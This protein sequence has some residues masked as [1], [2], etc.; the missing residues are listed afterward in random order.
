MQKPHIPKP[1]HEDWDAMT[2]QSGG[3]HC[4]KCDKV[5]I[6][7]TQNSDL[8]IVQYVSQFSKGSICG[9]ISANRQVTH[10]VFHQWIFTLQ[11]KATNI[12]QYF[13][14]S[15]L[16]YLIGLIMFVMGCEKADDKEKISIGSVR[17]DKKYFDSLNTDTSTPMNGRL[18]LD[19][20]PTNKEKNYLETR[21]IRRKHNP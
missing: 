8:E 19:I 17:F 3:R 15:I 7:F 13:T 12:N 20:I 9:R 1:C 11:F 5:V 16:L 18:E 14:R 4:S 6:D 21:K 2:P 10:S